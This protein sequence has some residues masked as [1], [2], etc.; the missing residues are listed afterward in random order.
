MHKART[1][2]F[3]SILIVV[4]S[5][6]LVQKPNREHRNNSTQSQ[7]DPVIAVQQ[8]SPS[9]ENIDSS[10]ILVKTINESELIIDQANFEYPGFIVC[11]KENNELAGKSDL[12]NGNIGSNTIKLSNINIGDKL[13]V[14]IYLDDGDGKLDTKKDT[15]AVDSVGNEI[16][17]SLEVKANIENGFVAPY[18][19]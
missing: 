5:V 9:G 6:A 11:I 13:D 19:L 14:L 2:A 1:L 10:S 12:L 4:I 15:V 8:S 16:K 7:I 17:L 3:A 18:G